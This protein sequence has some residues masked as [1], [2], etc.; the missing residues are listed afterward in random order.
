MGAN[1]NPESIQQLAA[2][3]DMNLKA[4]ESLERNTQLKLQLTREQAALINAASERGLLHRHQDTD[5]LGVDPK[6]SAPPP[7]VIDP[8][9]EKEN[10]PPPNLADVPSFPTSNVSALSA[11]PP[12]MSALSAPTPGMSASSAPTPGMSLSLVN[13]AYAM[14]SHPLTSDQAHMPFSASVSSQPPAGPAALPLVSPFPPPSHS[15]QYQQYTTYVH[16]KN[17]QFA[18]QRMMHQNQPHPSTSARN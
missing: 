18:Q 8:A 13:P 15:V 4:A 3:A 14:Y 12:G 10:Q 9:L 6:H 7:I 11:P 1:S 16:L 2:I 5:G 17:A